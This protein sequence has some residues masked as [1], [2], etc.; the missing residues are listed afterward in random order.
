MESPTTISATQVSARHTTSRTWS[1]ENAQICLEALAV[2][3][4]VEKKSSTTSI[5]PRTHV[6]AFEPVA[7]KSTSMIGKSL[8]RLTRYSMSVMQKLSLSLAGSQVPAVS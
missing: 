2:V 7:L 5:A 8:S 1:R 6:A 3:V 4:T